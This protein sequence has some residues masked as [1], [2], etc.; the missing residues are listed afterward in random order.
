MSKLP[1]LKILGQRA[2]VPDFA[3][4]LLLLLEVH[5]ALV[6]DLLEPLVVV[7]VGRHP[8]ALLGLRLVEAGPA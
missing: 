7:G 2:Q 1:Y 6:D 8:L 5:L 3:D 4:Q